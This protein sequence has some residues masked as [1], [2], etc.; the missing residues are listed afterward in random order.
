M[1]EL[2][3]R[4]VNDI[5]GALTRPRASAWLKAQPPRA[6]SGQAATGADKVKAD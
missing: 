3:R 2:A 4:M 5:E 6:V 1:E